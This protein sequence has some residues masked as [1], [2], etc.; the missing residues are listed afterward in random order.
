MSNFVSSSARG[1]KKIAT[2]FADL[3]LA[4]V[5]A[6]VRGGPGGFGRVPC[7]GCFHYFGGVFIDRGDHS[8]AGN[9]F[10]ADGR[11]ETFMKVG[12]ENAA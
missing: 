11:P 4:P 7:L 8:H 5:Q 10:V 1:D 6:I 9:A 12:Q 3:A 2:P